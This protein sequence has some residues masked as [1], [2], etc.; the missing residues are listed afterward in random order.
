MM[1]DDEEALEA[2]LFGLTHIIGKGAIDLP[3]GG[4]VD[5][6]RRGAAKKTELQVNLPL[7]ANRPAIYPKTAS[8][9]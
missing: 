7:L 1:L 9:R 8:A 2:Q 3:L 4:D 5:Q 6:A